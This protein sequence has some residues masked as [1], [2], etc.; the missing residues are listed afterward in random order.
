M[1][2]NQRSSVRSSGVQCHN[3][4]QH[5]DA[6]LCSGRQSDECSIIIPYIFRY[7]SSL[8]METLSKAGIITGN[9]YNPVREILVW[10]TS[11][12]HLTHL[13]LLLFLMPTDRRRQ[14]EAQ[15][16]HRGKRLVLLLSLAATFSNIQ[17]KL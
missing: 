5:F 3:L 12:L 9:N 17:V 15:E 8:V 10:M 6:R 4:S 14:I 7:M 11:A 13:M 2:D 16:I 1:N